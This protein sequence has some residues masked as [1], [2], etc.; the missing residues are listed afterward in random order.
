[1]VGDRAVDVSAAHRNGLE[2]AGVRWGYGSQEELE[3][4]QPRY[5]FSAPQELLSLVELDNADRQPD[6]NRRN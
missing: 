6:L 5:L 4:E 2:A 3:A 1:M